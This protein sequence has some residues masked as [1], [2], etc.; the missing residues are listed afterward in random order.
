MA[1]KRRASRAARSWRPPVGLERLVEPPDAAADALLGLD[2]RFAERIELMDKPLRM[3]PAER[4][5]R[6]PELAR[7]IGDDHRAVQEALLRNRSP[8]G[9]FRCDPDRIGLDL[10]AGE[11]EPFQIGH[12]G[13]AAGKA[14]K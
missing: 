1:S 2:M 5:L 12:E 4:M 3:H 7:A 9:A 11:A 6:D 13:F 10:K 14:L 8:K